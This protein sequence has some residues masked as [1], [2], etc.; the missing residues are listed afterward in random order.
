MIINQNI[1]SLVVKMN[2]YIYSD[3]SFNPQI[4]TAVCGY[5]KDGIINYVILENTTNINA[6]IYA[7]QMA[8]SNSDKTYIFGSDCQ[9]VI[10]MGLS[11]GCKMIKIKGHKPTSEKSQIDTEFSLL[12][13]Y[14]RKRLRLLIKDQ[15]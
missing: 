4:K 1:S 3:A 7:F 12:D 9:K 13:K 10:N 5:L 14:L 2:K 6:E 11:D 15:S 8:L